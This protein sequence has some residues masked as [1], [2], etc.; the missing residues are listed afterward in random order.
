MTHVTLTGDVDHDQ[1]AM[2]TAANSPSVCM[3]V[4]TPDGYE[5]GMPLEPFY[6]GDL[7]RAEHCWDR[8]E[9]HFPTHAGGGDFFYSMDEGAVDTFNRFIAEHL[10]RKKLV[11][12]CEGQAFTNVHMGKLL[13]SLLM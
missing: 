10:P 11:M 3:T 4:E 9:I 1:H 8:W 5:G 2:D 13:R 12:N 6:S 7:F